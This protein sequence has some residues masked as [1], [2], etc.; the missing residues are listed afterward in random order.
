[1]RLD[2]TSRCQTALIDLTIFIGWIGGPFLFVYLGEIAVPS[3]WP[4]I[5][6]LLISLVTAMLGF[7]VGLTAALQVEHA[8]ERY[9][10]VKG[11]KSLGTLRKENRE[12]SEWAAAKVAERKRGHWESLSEK[13]RMYKLWEM[14]E[15]QNVAQS[16]SLGLIQKLLAALICLAVATIMMI[17]RQS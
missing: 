17:V 15:S 16:Y 1:M 14:L 3:S 5:V 2:I 12:C 13:E 8:I 9:R 7:F 10:Q 11:M 6:K 4:N